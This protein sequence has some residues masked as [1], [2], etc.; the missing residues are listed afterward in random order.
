M[1]SYWRSAVHTRKWAPQQICDIVCEWWGN[2]SRYAA[3]FI[4][5]EIIFVNFEYDVRV[6]FVLRVGLL[7]AIDSLTSTHQVLATIKQPSEKGRE[8]DTR[9]MQRRQQ[10]ETRRVWNVLQNVLY[11]VFNSNS[12]SFRTYFTYFFR[13]CILHLVCSFFFSLL[14]WCRHTWGMG[15]FGIV[16]NMLHVLVLTLQL[17][18]SRQW[19]NI[20]FSVSIL[21]DKFSEYIYIYIE[22]ILFLCLPKR[23]QSTHSQPR[24]H[25]VNRQ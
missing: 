17:A 21:F 16:V 2:G 10:R 14:S 7:F 5:Y 3:R 12:M 13:V 18:R 23:L 15:D 4:R 19:I 11:Y 22:K 20:Y 8:W 6:S 1:K 24:A 9:A 25:N